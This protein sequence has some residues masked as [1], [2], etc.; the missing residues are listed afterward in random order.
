MNVIRPADLKELAAV[1]ADAN[2]RGLAVRPQGG[3]TKQ[4]WGNEPT[5][6]GVTLSTARINQVVEHAWADLTVTV[7][8]GCTVAALQRVLAARG[9]RLAVDPLWPEQATIGGVLSTN[10][11]GALRLSFGGLRD[12]ILGVTLVLPDGTIAQSGGK[13][14]KNVAGYDL[15]K[16]VTGALG[17]LGVITRATFR[18]YP[19]P[20]ISKT[21]TFEFPDLGTTQRFVIAVQGAKLA[22][23]ALQL[24][25]SG[26]D[27]KVHA[28]VLLEGTEAGIA[29]Q[30]RVI[31]GIACTS[32]RDASPDCWGA[33]QALWRS[34]VAVAKFSVLPTDLAATIAELQAVNAP[35]SVVAQA[36]GLGTVAFDG[37]AAELASHVKN[38][39][40][41]IER[42]GGSLAVFRKP[43]SDMETWGSAGDAL[44]LMRA[45]KNQ[46]DPKHTLNPGRFVGGI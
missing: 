28:D 30:E 18:L 45:L 13:V 34:S 1:L 21:L 32:P 6:S 23:T 25:V 19:L 20:M 17:T 14:V 42:T 12:L 11:T 8:A 3:G 44:P 31:C 5:R 4:D 15:P 33:R 22:H 36:T 46:F 24:R 40:A 7:E 16:L 43:A 38:I 2:S 10:D 29:A 35:C 27:G 26:V 37:P 39:R 41:S 9:Q